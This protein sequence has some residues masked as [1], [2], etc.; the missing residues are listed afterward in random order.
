MLL[1]I[2][3]F[4]ILILSFHSKQLI[5]DNYEGQFDYTE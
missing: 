1:W 5:R 3:C 4:I 2:H